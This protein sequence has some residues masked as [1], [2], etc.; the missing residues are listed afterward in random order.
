MTFRKTCLAV[1]IGSLCC[2]TQ[3]YAENETSDTNVAFGQKQ[4]QKRNFVVHL[5]RNVDAVKAQ[6]IIEEQVRAFATD[7]QVINSAKILG[8]F[9]TIQSQFDIKDQISK[10][11]NVVAVSSY[12]VNNAQDRL[13]KASKIGSVSASAE[14]AEDVMPL[15]PYL[16]DA[17]AGKGAS[18]A[19][20]STG[21]DYTLKFFGGSGELGEDNDPETP[22]TP[23]SYL[24]ALENG[25][26]EYAGFPTDVIVGGW[27]FTSENYGNDANPIDQYYSFTNWNGWEYPTGAGTQLASIVHQLAPGAAI[28]AYK[29][30]NVNESWGSGA[31]FDKIVA[32]LE[33]ALDPNQDGDTSD[34]VDIALLD[35]DGAA[36]FFDMDGI[37]TMS[38]PQHIIEKASALGMTIVADAGDAAE[39]SIK[40]DAESKHRYWLSGQ[41]GSTSSIAVGSVYTNDSDDLVVSDW[42]PK[43]PVRGSMALKPELVSFGEDHPVAMITQ[44]YVDGVETTTETM[45]TTKTEGIV[46]A[47]RIAAAAAVI[48]AKYGSVGPAEIK[49][50]L[51]NTATN[52]GIK[53][54]DAMTTAELVSVGHGVEN[55][56]AATTTPVFVWDSE[57]LQPYLQF[58]MH[59]VVDTKRIVKSLTIRNISESAQT[60]QLSNSS[61]DESRMQGVV[62]DYP[63]TVSVPAQ[64]ATTIQVTID[65]NAAELADWPL[66]STSDF[67]EANIKSTEVNGYITL[68]SENNPTLNVGWMVKSR[69]ATTISKDIITTE[70]P[71]YLGFDPE[72]YQS[73]Y[74]H[75]AWGESLFEPD[76]Y[77]GVG[78]SGHAASFV[79]D[80]KNDTTFHA[81]PLLINK[82][83]APTG[84]LDLKGHFIKK[85]GAGIYDD[86]QCTVTGKKFVVAVNLNVPANMAI[87]NFWDK[88]G[89]NL[90][91]YDLFHESVVADNGWADSFEGAYLWDESQMVNQFKISI[92]EAGQPVTYYTDYSMVYDWSQPNA[93]LKASVL[94]TLFNNEGTNIVSQ[95]CLEETF[96]H[97]IDS[98]ED[99]DQNLGFHIETDRDSGRAF[100]E[101]LVQFNPVKSGYYKS[102]EV[103]SEWGWCS[104][105]VTDKRTYVGFA[106]PSE[107]VAQEDLDFAHIITLAPGEEAVI[108]AVTAP[109]QGFGIGSLTFEDKSLKK[110]M[111]MSVN[112]DFSAVGYTGYQDE[113]GTIIA[114]VKENQEFTI[115]ENA[116]A[117]VIGS[118][119]LDSQAF[120]TYP[121]GERETLNV[122]I[123]SAVEGAPFRINSDFELELVNPDAIDFEVSNTLEFK[124]NTRQVNNMGSPVVVTVNVTNVNDIAPAQLLTEVDAMVDANGEFSVDLSNAFT[125]AEGDMLTLTVAAD[126]ILTPMTTGAVFSGQVEEIGEYD[127]TVTVADGVH[128]ETYSVMLTL[129]GTINQAPTIDA[130]VASSLEN[131]EVTLLVNDTGIVDFNFGGLFVDD[132][133][134]TFTATSDTLTDIRV[135]TNQF[136]TAIIPSVGT[137]SLTI[138]ATDG[139]YSVEFE[140]TVTGLEKPDDGGSLGFGILSLFGLLLL[141]RFK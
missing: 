105:V 99:F 38:L 111:V 83:D 123:L 6:R 33:H 136:I 77:G 40:G 8:N 34:H 54:S 25:A 70:Y 114:N 53:E 73:L 68:T 67:T 120:F 76:Q 63:E 9:I 18:V 49:A 125:D 48:K 14:V 113:D 91:F 56:E 118:V 58:G 139:T 23:G 51:A 24:E 131:Q 129:T 96:H 87:A 17:E 41:A 30:T 5:D 42:S 32:S 28:Y 130:D 29:V 21:V 75:L 35:G 45:F 50:L 126:S 112:D 16:G 66:N 2:F 124:V 46:A 64:G 86:A 90:F 26:I 82:N 116:E 10:L 39:V 78:Y 19:I 65:I 104:E 59:E 137:H 102:E 128:T 85:V 69:P 72:T 95:F 117:G 84:N 107:E 106:K 92:N 37:A 74:T 97:E 122:D 101:P 4:I 47:A 141:R 109:A 121:F 12:N 61:F 98:V 36:A 62:L 140:V 138:V 135:S 110:F 1:A 133:E 108:A 93:R 43:G 60:Y 80:S 20:I 100:G 94:P 7:A 27:D 103:C 3:A 57:S 31:S 11:S 127:L 71:T 22:P 13:N 134:L 52:A 132:S 115:A 89:D 44:P 55:L 81:Y 119:K 15:T 79:N 88:I